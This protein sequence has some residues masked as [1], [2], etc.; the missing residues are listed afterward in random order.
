M[1]M[2]KIYFLSCLTTM[3]RSTFLCCLT[4]LLIAQSVI[5]QNQIPPKFYGVNYWMPDSCGT[6][7]FDGK[8]AQPAISSKVIAAKLGIFR[9]GGNGFDEFGNVNYQYYK[10]CS[11]IVAMGGEPMVQI[12][13][14]FGNFSFTAAQAAALVYYLNVTKNMG[15]KYFSIGNEWDA[16]P[17]PYNR[18]D[19]ISKRIK[20][21]S[22][23]MKTAY[24]SAKDDIRIIGPA[25]T[26]FGAS[27]AGGS[28]LLQL[29]GNPVVTNLLDITIKDSVITGGTY[30]F[31]DV[32]DWHEY[33]F[34]MRNLNSGTLPTMK[35]NAISYPSSTAPFK[36]AAN[37]ST[38]NGYV[39]AANT[40]HGRTAAG[41]PLKYAVTEMNVTYKNPIGYNPATD[42]NDPTKNSVNG[43]ACASFFSGQ[44][45]ADMYSQFL[46][47]SNGNAL[48]MTPWSVYEKNGDRDTTDFGFLDSTF[49]SGTRE[50]STYYHS[51]LLSNNF[52]GKYYPG[53]SST[54]GVK[55]F[56]SVEAAGYKIMIL[57]QTNSSYDFRINNNGNPTPVTGFIPLNFNL[58]GDSVLNG[59]VTN[60]N[61]NSPTGVG[62]K[63]LDPNSTVVLTFDCHGNLTARVDYNLQ[64]AYSHN[65]PAVRQI[66]NNNVDP[67]MIACGMPG[68]GGVIN[69]SATYTGI[70]Y[71][72]SNLLVTGGTTT[73]TF[74]N[75]V[76]VVSPGVKIT[77][78]PNTTIKII[79]SVML[80]CGGSRW[81]GIEINSNYTG[82]NLI[83]QNSSI[84]N[85]DV[86]IKTAKLGDMQLTGSILA[87]GLGS[88]VEMDRAA[89]YTISGNIFAG[90]VSGITSTKAKPASLATIDN[91]QFFEL[92]TAIKLVDGGQDQLSILC[93]NMKYRQEAITS[94]KTDLAV[95][96]S[97]SLSA[98]N[99]FVKTTSILPSG[100]LN[101]SG[102]ATQYYYGT[103]PMQTM[104]FSFPGV[105]NV[106]I[107]MAAADRVCATAFDTICP[108]WSMVGIHEQINNDVKPQMLVY[109]NPSQ[110]QFTVNF[111]NLPKGNWTLSVFDVMGRVISSQKI[112]ATLE[113]TTL[114]IVSKGFYFVTLQSGNNR[115]TQ[116]VIV[117]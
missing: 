27:D 117:E 30:Y 112:E 76:V 87:N 113:S 28:L 73:L 2:K 86:P 84:L 66:G 64:D 77:G 7:F 40:A 65:P 99:S 82:L 21:F 4:L 1:P 39:S 26:W 46:K 9:V 45:L 20:R 79:G 35:A 19:T 48:F 95:Q 91:N 67:S 47:N 59:N 104:A 22:H 50:R 78:N 14:K 38:M 92:E 31:I 13:V 57:N 103:S 25:L 63:P 90:F 94:I 52:I 6:Q 3:K 80:G 37:L 100:Y 98:G 41:K 115:V 83:V 8:I 109:P 23:A 81:K 107:V 108:P 60:N 55:A 70:V 51:Q 72:T 69:S 114:Q 106:P 10:A 12:P 116:K 111:S 85:A 110:G 61:Y 105:M 15:I 75:A 43:I 56:A 74:N 96:G 68:I 24:P 44:F 32:I 93:N 33:P 49:L 62:A 17:A 102:T 5:S 11:T 101:H 53:T 54:T 18:A 29:V 34:N 97:A 16:Y 58:A 89:K 88:A 71:V 36:F 42:Y